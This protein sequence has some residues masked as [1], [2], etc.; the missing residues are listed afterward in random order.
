[1]K[2]AL[3]IG[4]SVELYLYT[5]MFSGVMDTVMIAPEAQKKSDE[6]KKSNEFYHDLLVDTRVQFSETP[7][8]DQSFNSEVL[9]EASIILL[10]SG[11]EEDK[12]LASYAEHNSE[13]TTPI[14]LTGTHDPGTTQRYFDK[15]HLN[16]FYM[17]IF[18]IGGISRYAS[19]QAP[20]GVVLGWT[21]QEL[22]TPS[23][24][25]I[26]ETLI[27]AVD[28][29]CTISPN[30]MDPNTAELIGIVAETHALVELAF[31]DQVRMLCEHTD[32]HYENLANAFG[33]RDELFLGN[34]EDY[35][36]AAQEYIK[37]FRSK[38]ESQD[39]LVSKA[40]NIARDY[41]KDR[42]I[43]HL[44]KLISR[45]K[46]NSILVLGVSSTPWVKND[47]QSRSWVDLL[48][49]SLD[50]TEL[51]VTIHDPRNNYI[52]EVPAE[53]DLI[54]LG[55]PEYLSKIQDVQSYKVLYDPLGYKPFPL[56]NRV[57]YLGK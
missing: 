44:H 23:L 26:N 57:Q 56:D 33:F 55:S 13:S 39:Y 15:Y 19:I 17:P 27:K 47:D 25:L 49:E 4:S 22:L 28:N 16:L 35:C 21:D 6:L 14:I 52:T 37:L 54:I 40:L 18:G 8:V 41:H 36:T 53:V 43:D 3:V 2:H 42:M 48:I 11:A 10:K 51:E 1:M 50:S 38:V 30:V 31:Y 20:P 34:P 9:T 5:A 46:V 29:T 7:I 12:I 32:S 45:Y 24:D